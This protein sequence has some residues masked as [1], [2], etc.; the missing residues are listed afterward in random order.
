MARPGVTPLYPTHAVAALFVALPDTT[1][2]GL[3]RSV[4]LIVVSDDRTTMIGSLDTVS[5]ML[6]DAA[7]QLRN[8]A[9]ATF[10]SDMQRLMGP[11]LLTIALVHDICT[12]IGPVELDK[13]VDL[14][15]LQAA[16]RQ[17]VLGCDMSERWNQ[18]AISALEQLLVAESQPHGTLH[19]L[20]KA[21][22]M[23]MGVSHGANFPWMTQF[24]DAIQAALSGGRPKLSK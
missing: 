10:G 18:D 17:S 5:T 19:A 21:L 1:A 4:C 8:G 2:R 6:S 24:N 14:E 13:P 9:I 22:E 11:L 12:I 15:A 20:R 7:K 16:I 23:L 3:T